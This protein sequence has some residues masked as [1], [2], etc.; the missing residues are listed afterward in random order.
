MKPNVPAQSFTQASF[1]VQSDISMVGGRLLRSSTPS[2]GGGG[3][4]EAPIDGKVYARQNSAWIELK[5]YTVSI[6]MDGIEK[7]IDVYVSGNPY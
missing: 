3:I 1:N 6:C 2:D 4:P 7:N 5:T